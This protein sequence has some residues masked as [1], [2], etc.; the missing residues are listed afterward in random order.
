MKLPGGEN[1]IVDRLKLT[2]YCLADHHP[3]GKHKARA[4]SAVPGL[5]AES[6]DS[7]RTALLRAAA[8]ASATP[9]ARDR[10]GQR[11]VVDFEMSGSGGTGIV[12]S[13]GILQA[14]ENSPRLASC[15]LL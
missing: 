6:A 8:S 4:F 13:I 15:Y 12:R 7:L 9:V 3:R 10:Y 11:Y 1:A 14:G 2:E 5:T